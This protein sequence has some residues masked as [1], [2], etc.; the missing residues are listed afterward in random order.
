MRSDGAAGLAGAGLLMAAGVGD[1][2]PGPPGVEGA[3]ARSR[4]G[5]VWRATAPGGGAGSRV[6]GRWW[7]R[8][9]GWPS[10]LAL[11][12]LGG[13]FLA[14]GASRLRAGHDDAAGWAMVAVGPLLPLALGRTGRDRTYGLVATVPVVAF[15]A[16]AYAV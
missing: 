4:A 3:P 16:I 11:V 12:L 9:S 6:A 8:R 7:R 13:A 10:W 15:T 5:G 14:E 2:A 1:Y